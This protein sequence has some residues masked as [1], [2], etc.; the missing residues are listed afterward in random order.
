MLQKPCI[1]I[2][3]PCSRRAR[4]FAYIGGTAIDVEVLAEALLL[5]AGATRFK[6]SCL[7]LL[8]DDEPKGRVYELGI[9]SVVVTPSFEVSFEDPTVPTPFRIDTRSVGSDVR[10]LLVVTGGK[11]SDYLEITLLPTPDTG[12]KGKGA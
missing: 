1:P 5:P 11:V 2:T 4:H 3:R 7:M 12:A 6:V 10:F 8:N 9:D